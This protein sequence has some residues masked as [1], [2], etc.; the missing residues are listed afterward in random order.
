M[1][2]CSLQ[3]IIIF[4][5]VNLSQTSRAE[6]F[7]IIPNFFISNRNFEYSVGNGGVDGNINSLGLGLTGIY[8]RF[9]IDL[10]GERNI[11]ASEEST[12][13][14]EQTNIVEFDRTDFAL[15]IGYAVNDAISA[16]AGYKYGKSTITAVYPSPFAGGKISLEEQ[17][18]FV[19]AG[20]RVQINNWGFLSFSAA[21]A[22]MIATYEDLALLMDRG[23]ASGTSLGVQWKASLTERLY[24]DV[25]L[26]RHDYY[27]ENFEEFELD[28]SEQLFSIRIGLSYRF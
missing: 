6:D 13:N 18:G 3:L 9:Y 11:T 24:Y 4:V 5:S 21:Y 10:S 28:I 27:H 12:I 22:R 15:S 14:L 8:Q 19:G 23:D 25:S 7:F 20:G 17:G 2:P 26:I 1:K 16:F